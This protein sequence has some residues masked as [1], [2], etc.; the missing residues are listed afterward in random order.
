MKKIL[1]VSSSR[2]FLER[3][4]TLLTRESFELFTAGGGE[5]ALRLQEEHRFDLVLADLH[6]KDLEGDAVCSRLRSDE[7]YGNTAVILI[8]YDK[9]EEHERVSRCGADAKI[10]RPIQPEQMIETVG[11]LLEMQLTRTQRVIFRVRVLSKKGAVEFDCV[12]LDISITGILL[13]TEHHLDIGDRIICRFTLPGA[14]MMET[15]GDVVRSAK[16][17]ESSI[18]YGVQFVG[19]SLSHRREIERYVASARK[20]I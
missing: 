13:E 2:S 16:A 9:A 14:S 8:C 6:L 20:R 12:S 11:S 3:N 4:K 10:I 7:N 5:E 1:L 18:R 15:E 19:L 17:Q